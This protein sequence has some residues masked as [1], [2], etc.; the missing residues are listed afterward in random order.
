MDWAPYCR[1]RVHAAQVHEGHA[2]DQAPVTGGVQAGQVRTERV[3]IVHC[4][5]I[6]GGG[7]HLQQAR[8]LDVVFKLVPAQCRVS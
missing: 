6:A 5:P 8:E 2:V 7:R 4:G 1:R 3:E